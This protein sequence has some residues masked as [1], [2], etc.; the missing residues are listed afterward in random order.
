MDDLLNL[1]IVLLFVG[2]SLYQSISQAKKKRQQ[3]L[4]E[5][6]SREEEIPEPTVAELDEG[7]IHRRPMARPAAPPPQQAGPPTPWED[8]K[9]QL[10][11]V[12]SE[13]RV[14]RPTAEAAPMPTPAPPRKAAPPVPRKRPSFEKPIQRR[15]EPARPEDPVR[16]MPMPPRIPEHP[17]PTHPVPTHPVPVRDTPS[18]SARRMVAARNQ[19]KEEQTEFARRL[20]GQAMPIRPMR[21][22]RR[23]RTGD[24]GFMKFFEDPLV[25]AVVMTEVL[26]RRPYDRSSGVNKKTRPYAR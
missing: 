16:R 13:G 15:T 8:L 6:L 1:I 10:E 26:G 12:L 11:E 14:T 23:R 2:G 4:E 9:R 21:R 3:E 25:N 19:Q 5:A 24:T 22:R 17:V 7:Q 20:G 18:K